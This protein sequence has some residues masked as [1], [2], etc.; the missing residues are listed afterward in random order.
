[1]Y[2]ASETKSKLLYY[3][4]SKAQTRPTLSYTGHMMK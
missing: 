3:I 4:L 1:M 2:T